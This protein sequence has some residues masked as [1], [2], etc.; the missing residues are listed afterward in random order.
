[1]KPH[2]PQETRKSRTVAQVRMHLKGTLGWL[3]GYPAERSA[4][5]A[6]RWVVPAPSSAE[7][8]E[9]DRALVARSVR[10][11]K[12]L[13]SD[14]PDALPEV[15]GDV[16]V[17]VDGAER[18]T[19]WAAV[20]IRD[21]VPQASLF[22][23]EPAYGR[24]AGAMARDVVARFPV[25][26]S[27]VVAFSFRGLVRPRD[28]VASLAHL[29][30]HADAFARATPHV[31]GTP[32]ERLWLELDTVRGNHRN[33]PQVTRGLERVLLDPRTHDAAVREG[34]AQARA[35]HKALQRLGKGRAA[36]LPSVTPPAS[37]SF[38]H[39][40]VKWM[41]ELGAMDGAAQKRALALFDLLGPLEAVERWHTFWETM[42]LLAGRA[43]ALQRAMDSAQRAGT[44]APRGIGELE[45][46]TAALLTTLPPDE[47]PERLLEAI[48]ALSR[49][50]SRVAY[51]D[52]LATLAMIPP[53]VDGRPLRTEL[54]VDWSSDRYGGDWPK[55]LRGFVAG[56]RPMLE[57]AGGDVAP[58]L[59][60][61]VAATRRGLYSS[62]TNTIARYLSTPAIRARFF[63]VWEA[64]ARVGLPA[65]G[66]DRAL[67][68]AR[69][70]PHAPDA[71]T[72]GVWLDHLSKIE[73]YVSSELIALASTLADGD[74]G[75]FG[76][77]VDLAMKTRFDHRNTGRLERWMKGPERKAMVREAL[78]DGHV[79]LLDTAFSHIDTLVDAGKPV[80]EPFASREPVPTSVSLDEYPPELRPALAR[81]VAQVADPEAAITRVLGRAF[82]S[83]G[84]LERELRAIEAKRA[85]ADTVP[86][87]RRAAA[88][89]RQRD[90]ILADPSRST[91][92]EKLAR[93]AAKVELAARRTRLENWIDAL[94]RAIDQELDAILDLGELA[95]SPLLRAPKTR[96]CVVGIL[97]LDPPSRA[98]A[99]MVL[100]ARLEGEAWDFRAH[101][102]NAAFIASLVRRGVD[103]APWLDGIGPW[104]ESTPDV[105][106]ITL[107]LE[108][109]P[110]ELLEMGK[111]FGTCLSPTA[112][113]YFSVFANIVDVNKRVLYA[114]DAHGKVLGR[115]LMA[116]TTAGG[117]LTFHAYRH[118]PMDF[119][120]MVKRFAG[121]LSRRMGVTV[122]ASGKVKVLVAPDWYDDGP[123][124]RSGRLSFLEAGS[125]FRAALASVALPEVHALC[126]R[127]MAP[128]GPSELTL[129]SVL[130]L[131]EVAARPEL[132][133]AFA[134]MVAGLHAVPEH[135]LMR[136]AHLLHAAGRTDL[137]EEDAVFGAVSRLERSTSGVS[138]PLLRNLAPLFPSSTLRLLRQTRERGV[139]TLED[140]WNAHRILA[141]AE[142]MRA[143]FRERKALELYR[144]AVKK[145]LSNAD[146][147]HCRT[148]MKALK[149]AVTRATRPAG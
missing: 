61:F 18:V 111:H 89:E 22:E 102:A 64:R 30:S 84:D 85:I 136:L 142:A 98:I 48:S 57:R 44:A 68:L 83:R 114:R 93:I 123:V 147:A 36:N 69:T 135:L 55:L 65:W 12:E 140:E 139:R 117:I 76:V 81:L 5:G 28:A 15:V 124:D 47:T 72:A 20:A 35:L 70:V 2:R 26:R 86:L 71:A 121:E 115:C 17:F 77:L 125:E 38:G 96:E 54:L 130:E 149:Q 27:T 137:L 42:Q 43:S 97:G 40:L 100:R 78:L 58:L 10:T 132:A 11:V 23:L 134:P 110:L 21:G 138:G 118:G 59:H 41:P 9:V 144:L 133:V 75:T 103:P 101:P 63:A 91:S 79:S 113:N 1:M 143:L 19:R 141:A 53:L 109:D 127:S 73:G 88:L 37:T 67:L 7:H 106:Q 60:P 32:P 116:L 148:Q 56:V 94:E 24:A 87:A 82:R 128:L 39:S 45:R 29:A 122:L 99:R 49:P 129:P 145:G 13:A 131:P 51:T 33:H 74:G 3:E 120:G 146:R 92:P 14:F 8:R 126:E 107:A 119:E 6:L 34:G 108:D 16:K 62:L 105:G 90:A 66:D 80:P 31:R 52:I 95:R 112:F 4:S 46:K 25:L 50:E 104:V